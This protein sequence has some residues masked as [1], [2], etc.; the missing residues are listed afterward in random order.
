MFIVCFKIIKPFLYCKV[1]FSKVADLTQ[2]FDKQSHVKSLQVSITY[3][4][5]L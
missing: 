4:D 5:Q 3:I 2:C 1:L